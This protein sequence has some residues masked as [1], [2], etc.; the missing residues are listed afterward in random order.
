MNTNRLFA[1][2]PKFLS[3]LKITQQHK[4]INLYQNNLKTYSTLQKSSNDRFTQ[5]SSKIPIETKEDKD[6]KYEE[7]LFYF[8]RQWNKN[9]AEKIK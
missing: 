6:F 1:K 2:L 3:T 7:T 8:N 4:L 5:I 9:Q